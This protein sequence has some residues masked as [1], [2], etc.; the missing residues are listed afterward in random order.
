MDRKV[1]TLVYCELS[2]VCRFVENSHYFQG[3]EVYGQG[4]ERYTDPPVCTV[5][6]MDFRSGQ[7]DGFLDE[8]IRLLVTKC[9][10]CQGRSAILQV[11]LLVAR[12]RSLHSQMLSSNHGTFYYNQLAALQILINDTAG[13]QQSLKGYFSTLYLDQIDANGDQVR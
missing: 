8:A 6:Q 3:L 9:R 1:H 5:D 10:Y 13:A 7:P 4:R 2:N 12:L 11:P